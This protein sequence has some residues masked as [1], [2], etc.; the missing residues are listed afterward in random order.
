MGAEPLDTGVEVAVEAAGTTVVITRL[1]TI[2]RTVTTGRLGLSTLATLDPRAG[3]LPW[4]NWYE[5]KTR[6]ARNIAAE[7]MNTRMAG[8]L[9]LRMALARSVIVAP[10]ATF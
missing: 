5:R 8:G 10:L 9:R 4:A 7:A 3:S 2:F 6:A 1:L